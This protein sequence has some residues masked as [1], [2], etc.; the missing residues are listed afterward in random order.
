LKGATP[1]PE[2][3]LFACPAD[4]FYYDV[5]NS[6]DLFVVNQSIHLKT[7]YNYS[8]YDF[9]AGNAVFQSPQ[10][11]LG[12]WPGILGSKLNSVRD[13]VKTVLVAE[14]PAFWS[15]SW[16]QPSPSGR[17][18]YNNAPSMVSFVDG[19]VSYVKMY[20]GTNNPYNM[21]APSSQFNPP[22]GYDYKW[23]GD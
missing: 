8:S 17:T 10:N 19:H 3:K 21:G 1:S 14:F 13:A 9:N 22:A 12:Q 16:H 4:T 2:D 15:Y 6:R 18:E 7:N 5:T 23:S 11:L 20:M